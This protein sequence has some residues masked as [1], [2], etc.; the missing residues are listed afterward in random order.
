MKKAIILLSLCLV[1]IVSLAQSQI[2][3]AV[4]KQVRDSIFH[5]ADLISDDIQ[6][7]EYLRYAF[8]QH[9]GLES[10]TEYL[11]AALALCIR[12]KLNTEE[13]WVLFDYCRQYEYRAELVKEE[14]WLAKLKKASYQYKEYSFYYTMWFSVLQ[15]HCSQGNTEY[16][17]LQ[18]K[19]MK[20]EANRL[21]YDNGLFI[22]SLALAQAYDFA[23]RNKEAI[24]AYL[25]ILKESPNANASSLKTIYGNL[26]G[27]YQK[28]KMYPEAIDALQHQLDALKKV[29]EDQTSDI[30]KSTLLGIEISLCNIY[31]QMEDKE[32]LI[33][34]LRSA[35]KY[36]NKNTYIG[37]YI[38]YHALWASYYRLTKEWDKCFYEFDIALSACRGTNPFRENKVLIMQ[39]AALLETGDFKRAAEA[40]KRAAI[41]GDSLNQSTLLKHKEAHQANYK[42]QNAL[43][44]KEL[45]TK[46]YLFI[47]VSAAAIIL[48]ILIFI[49]IRTYL[50]RRQVQ[51]SEEETRRAFETIKA[52]D[53]MKE[54]FLHNISYEIRIPLNTVVG[55]AEILSSESDIGDEEIIEY[56]AM[57][58]SNSAKLLSLINNILDLSRLEAG[59]MKF[60]VQENDMVQLCKDAKMMV[61]MGTPNAVE[62]VF[63]T[64]LE[65]LHVE[66]DSKWFLKL[67]TSLLAVP[68]DYTGEP[69]RVEYS[70]SKEDGNIKIVIK[71]S[72]F[73]H[74]EKEEQEQHIQLDINRLYIEAFKGSYQV[75][76]EGGETLVTIIYPI[77]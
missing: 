35:Q 61:E 19:E 12:K 53:K 46:R 66:L 41:R 57:V 25:Q 62:L 18:A 37:T 27:N 13:L 26:A 24:A 23:D 9:I 1:S 14:E 50:F 7:S 43:L 73:Y 22:A 11:D 68:K 31:M 16:A 59:M 36:Y 33:L 69:Y 2:S 4:N 32:N 30:Y 38:D 34:H 8:Q 17:I 72:P 6:R 3:E 70:L 63:N 56:S 45:L 29:P 20:A 51:Y 65:S 47:Q 15:A 10:A 64:K 44:E 71:N 28:L 40:Y 21:N 55:F 77:K 60:N 67:L 76:R 54:C 42:I 75:L 49:I 5:K 39:A 58:K 74:F 48:F 52:A